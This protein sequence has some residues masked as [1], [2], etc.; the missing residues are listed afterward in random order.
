[1][2]F[3]YES[4]LGGQDIIRLETLFRQIPTAP[5][6]YRDV[7]ERAYAMGIAGRKTVLLED[8]RHFQAVDRSQTTEARDRAERWY[9]TVYK[10]LWEKQG[11]NTK[12]TSEFL[13]KIRT[14][15]IETEAEAIEAGGYAEKYEIEFG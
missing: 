1:M 7:Y 15:S 11:H 5:Y 13:N 12:R 8:F 6:G 3:A 14:G 2:P 4:R 9:Q 10:P